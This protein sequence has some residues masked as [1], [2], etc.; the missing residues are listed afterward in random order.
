VAGKRRASRPDGLEKRS[1]QPAR[2]ARRSRHPSPGKTH[3]LTE[4]DTLVLNPE[5]E[6]DL[7]ALEAA[8][9]LARSNPRT[10]DLAPDARLGML[11]RLRAGAEA[12]RG[13]FLGGSPWTTRPRPDA[14]RRPMT[15]GYN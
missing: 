7:H 13:A 9:T 5:L 4:G 15:A 1:L 10:E 3:F 14:S 6:L 12:Y 11:R 8:Y 2:Y